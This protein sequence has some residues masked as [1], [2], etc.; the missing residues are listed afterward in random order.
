M[1]VS[2][3]PSGGRFGYGFD[4]WCVECETYLGNSSDDEQ[5]HHPATEK[6][7]KWL[8]KK[9]VPCKCSHAGE[10]YAMPRHEIAVTKIANAEVSESRR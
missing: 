4:Y 7:G 2:Y 10:T 8:R 9:T 6:E 1:N 3:T 5:L